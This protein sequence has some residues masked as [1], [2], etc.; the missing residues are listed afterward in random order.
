M[1]FLIFVCLCFKRGVFS[2]EIRACNRNSLFVSVA[3]I[4]TMQTQTAAFSIVLEKEARTPATLDQDSIVN[5]AQNSAE[6][7]SNYIR[8]F[9]YMIFIWFIPISN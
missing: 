7:L 4:A 6:R 3:P 9:F 8:K 5:F 1:L 2:R